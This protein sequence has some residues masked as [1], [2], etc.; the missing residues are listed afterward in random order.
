VLLPAI[1]LAAMAAASAQ[2]GYFGPPPGDGEVRQYQ[3]SGN[4]LTTL[5]LLLSNANGPIPVNMVI[6]TERKARPARGEAPQVRLEFQTLRLHG[7]INVRAPHVRLTR[8]RDT[9]TEWVGEYSV[10]SRVSLEL[11]VAGFAIAC[12]AATLQHLSSASTLHGTLLGIDFVL[13]PKQL[14]AIKTFAERR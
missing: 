5:T 14:Q 6:V 3:Q 4:T 10:D 2:T 9:A 12:D 8:D 11:P 13:T 1:W 7:P